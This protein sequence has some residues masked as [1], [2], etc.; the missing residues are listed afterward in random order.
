MKKNFIGAKNIFFAADGLA[1]V[2][3]KV[4]KKISNKN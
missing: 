1:G 3:C 4:I 2:P